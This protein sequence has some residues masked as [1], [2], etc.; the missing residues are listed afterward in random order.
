[1]TPVGR[2]EL[3]RIPILRIPTD[4]SVPVRLGCIGRDRRCAAMQEILAEK[5]IDHADLFADVL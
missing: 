4:H 5:E 3:R 1:M 2:T